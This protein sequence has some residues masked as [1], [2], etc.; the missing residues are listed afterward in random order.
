ME[1]SEGGD[2][3]G[4]STTTGEGLPNVSGSMWERLGDA[5][6]RHWEKSCT[7]PSLLTTTPVEEAVNEGQV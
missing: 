1:G 7:E 5:G 6:E 2:E 3:A 4:G